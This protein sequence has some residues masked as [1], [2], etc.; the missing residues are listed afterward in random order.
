MGLIIS[1]IDRKMDDVKVNISLSPSVLSLPSLRRS[2]SLPISPSSSIGRIT[3]FD[4]LVSFEDEF[5]SFEDE[6]DCLSFEE[7]DYLSEDI[8]V[9][10]LVCE[11]F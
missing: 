10:Y 8:E 5:V 4:E 6:N 2:K 7:N 3:T 9:E 1:C 11:N